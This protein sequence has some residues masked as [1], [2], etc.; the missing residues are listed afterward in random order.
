M[1]AAWEELRATVLTKPSSTPEL[2]SFL[3][4]TRQGLHV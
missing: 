2:K 3:K 4:T 1:P